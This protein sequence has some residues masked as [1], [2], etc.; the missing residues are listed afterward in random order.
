MASHDTPSAPKKAPLGLINSTGGTFE[1]PKRRD[2]APPG[3]I[4]SVP[5]KP[6]V[7]SDDDGSG[8]SR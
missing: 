4:N 3:L 7:E 5:L 8:D 1:T 6:D 2:G